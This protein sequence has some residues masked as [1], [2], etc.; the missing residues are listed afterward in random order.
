MLLETVLLVL[1]LITIELTD[2]RREDCDYTN[3][4]DH[5]CDL[6]E[7]V[8]VGDEDSVELVEYVPGDTNLIFSVPHDGEFKLRSVPQREPGCGKVGKDKSACVYTYREP[9][10]TGENCIR[11]GGGKCTEE[12][13][14][15]VVTYVDRNTRKIAR[16]AWE[17]FRDMTG[18]TPHLVINHLHR[19]QLDP[20]REIEQAAEGNEWSKKTYN[21][22]HNTIEQV[23]SQM[24]GPGLLVDFHGQTHKQNFTEIGYLFKPKELNSGD[25]TSRMPSISSL[26][27]R[28]GLAIQELVSGK[29]SLGSL[30]ELEGV[31][32]VPSPR[33]PSPGEDAYYAGGYITQVHG[34]RDGGKVDAVQLEFPSESRYEGGDKAWQDL[35]DSLVRGLA[36][37]YTMFYL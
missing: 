8:E 37:W 2:L 5:Q 24:S 14:C 3:R 21:Q 10:C 22:F 25:L 35:S 13:S 7:W 32:S 15:W 18:L 29:D 12:K 11:P 9:G 26:K 16:R 33:Q 4:Y 17:K 34:S 31:R 28:T 20:N 6:I 23:K 19:S 27:S 36:K 30:L 1:S